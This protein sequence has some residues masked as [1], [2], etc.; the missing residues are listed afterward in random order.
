MNMAL[1]WYSVP[2]KGQQSIRKAHLKTI[3]SRHVA[4][5]E[6]VEQFRNREPR[7][8]NSRAGPRVLSTP[9]SLFYPRTD[10]PENDSTA[11]P[12]TGCPKKRAGA[13]RLVRSRFS[14]WDR[15]AASFGPETMR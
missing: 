2:E 13:N 3:Y 10:T 9:C 7:S 11:N 12:R 6:P 8:D 14:I 1:S 15:V 4:Q 5:S